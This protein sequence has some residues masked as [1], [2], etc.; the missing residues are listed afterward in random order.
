[1]Q[2]S[3]RDADVTVTGGRKSDVKHTA[4]ESI[5]RRLVPD[6]IKKLKAMGALE[7]DDAEPKF[8][9]SFKIGG[10]SLL[11]FYKAK[12]PDIIFAG[13]SKSFGFRTLRD[14]SIDPKTLK[15]GLR[16][17]LARKFTELGTV[18]QGIKWGDEIQVS[19]GFGAPVKT[20]V[21]SARRAEDAKAKAIIKAAEEAK[22]EEIT[23]GDLEKVI[24][25]V[26]PGGNDGGGGR[27]GGGGKKRKGGGSNKCVRE[28]QEF[29][30][31]IGDKTFTAKK[32]TF[33][34]SDVDGD[35]GPNTAYGLYYYIV[36]SYKREDDSDIQKASEYITQNELMQKCQDESRPVRRKGYRAWKEVFKVLGYPGK[37]YKEICD[38]V[39]A[40]KAAKPGDD[41]DDKKPEPK[42]GSDEEKDVQAEEFYDHVLQLTNRSGKGGISVDIERDLLDGN[43]IPATAIIVPKGGD[44]SLYRS[45]AKGETPED[46]SAWRKAT[47]GGSYFNK[48]TAYTK[49]TFSGVNLAYDYN[50]QIL[51]IDSNMGDAAYKDIVVISSSTSN[52]G[53]ALVHTSNPKASG[54]LNE[55]SYSFNNK[56]LLREFRKY[57][58][59]V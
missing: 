57:L 20:P 39:E 23:K 27:K 35:W 40:V 53:Y 50:S 29:F 48:E 18:F 56:K 51:K 43:G 31:E 25:N 16:P 24:A 38:F 30:V 41:D 9:I 59:L 42:P 13:G 52:G 1:M 47:I 14:Q 22:G 5:A 55:T 4:V 32:K 15:K 37:S 36:N 46:V 3:P 6:L 58:N 45:C 7:Q 19:I 33:K 49:D 21:I 28:L 10:G 44:L 12:K 2:E 8:S 54:K 17:F 34:Q 26:G 11:P